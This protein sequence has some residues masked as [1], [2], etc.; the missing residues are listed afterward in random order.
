METKGEPKL[1]SPSMSPASIITLERTSK[2]S[3][4]VSVFHDVIST[5]ISYDPARVAIS[6]PVLHLVPYRTTCIKVWSMTSYLTLQELCH[7]YIAHTGIQCEIT[8]VTY[9]GPSESVV[10]CIT[11]PEPQESKYY[12]GTY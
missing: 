3:W 11:G 2:P 9:S 5:I 1:P 7:H 6:D 4:E 12:P 10:E 8:N